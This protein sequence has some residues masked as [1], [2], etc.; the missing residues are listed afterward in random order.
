MALGVRHVTVTVN[1]VDPRIGARIYTHV[2]HNE[3]RLTG[4]DG[5][6]L[7][8]AK[9]EQ[10]V[11]RLKEH[12][13]TVKINTVIIPGINDI[14]APKV[15]E[16]VARWG[17]DIMNCLA[18]LSVAGTPLGKREPPSPALMEHIR[19]EAGCFLPQMRHCARC[20]ADAVG[21]LGDSGRLEDQ[22]MDT[23]PNPCAGGSGRSVF[24]DSC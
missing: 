22:V 12:G 2:T 8:L 17:A 14:H 7:L 1:A 21:L 10:G 3:E 24:P 18:L 15:A 11:R 9:Q 20:R 13:V 6:A 23:M 16:Q 4:T 5:A 19:A